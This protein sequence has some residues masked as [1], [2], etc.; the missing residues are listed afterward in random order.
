MVAYVDAS[1]ADVRDQNCEST[2]GYLI[3]SHGDLIAWSTCKQKTVSPS[4]AQAEYTAL[5][6]AIKE[7]TFVRQLH[8]DIC[9]IEVPARIFEDN[10]SAIRIAEG[11]ESSSSRFLLTKQFAIRQAVMDGEVVIHKISSV[12]QLADIMTKALDKANF[13]RIRCFLLESINN[14]KRELR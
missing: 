9:K 13:S 3:F 10:T 12:D 2:G 7:I 1:F 5:N 4:T 8:K 11:T 6:D 14:L